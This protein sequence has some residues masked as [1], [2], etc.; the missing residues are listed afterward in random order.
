MHVI[1]LNVFRQRGLFGIRKLLKKV[2]VAEAPQLE[3]SGS[4][5]KGKS[6]PFS[7]PHGLKLQKPINTMATVLE[8]GHVPDPRNPRLKIQF[9]PATATFLN[10]SVFQIMMPTIRSRRLYYLKYLC[11]L[12]TAIK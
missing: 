1:S 9:L 3:N 11:A 5:I 6:F 12:C 8:P 2:D 4:K 10:S 7:L